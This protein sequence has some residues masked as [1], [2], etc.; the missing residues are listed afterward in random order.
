M[1]VLKAVLVVVTFSILSWNT[2]I[3]LD[4]SEK[5]INDRGTISPD[6]TFLVKE[7]RNATS[8]GSQQRTIMMQRILGLEHMHGMHPKNNIE[9]CPGCQQKKQ[10]EAGQVVK[11]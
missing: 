8:F 3:L 9:M 5:Q 10:E 6:T 11:K 4:V 1:K 2:K 7:I